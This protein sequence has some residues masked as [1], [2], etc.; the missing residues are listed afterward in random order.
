MEFIGQTQVVHM[1]IH[2]ILKI[3]YSK[4][5]RGMGFLETTTLGNG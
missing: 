3:I 2:F 5:V 4:V 1:V